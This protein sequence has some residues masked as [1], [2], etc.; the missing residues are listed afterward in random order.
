MP[1]KSIFSNANKQ[2]EAKD[3]ERHHGKTDGGTFQ[4]GV[5]MYKPLDAYGGELPTGTNIVLEN[6][7]EMTLYDGRVKVVD[8]EYF[9]RETSKQ[10]KRMEYVETMA[11]GFLAAGD[12][13]TIKIIGHYFD[14]LGPGQ[15]N[16]PDYIRHLM[17]CLILEGYDDLQAR[18]V[19][20]RFQPIDGRP[21]TIKT[22][23]NSSQEYNN[24]LRKLLMILKF[25][26]VVFS[27]KDTVPTPNLAPGQYIRDYQPN[28]NQAASNIALNETAAERGIDPNILRA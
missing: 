22:Y 2:K 13:L 19:V 6:G 18:T 1:T 21:S 11:E 24:S 3:Y 4:T 20:E 28:P 8:S 10:K 27:G 7:S 9:E 14:Y 26:D 12:G 16:N 15:P 25:V 23:T 17:K 5:R